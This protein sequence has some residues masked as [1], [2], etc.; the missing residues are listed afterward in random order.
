MEHKH[1]DILVI[2]FGK[3]G[4]TLAGTMG[5]L[6]KNVAMIEQSDTMYGG[7]CINIGCVPTKSLVHQAEN[8]KLAAA[9]D[10]EWHH[11]AVD[12]TRRLTTAM[13]G[14]NFETLDT[15]DT[16]TVITGRATFV[17]PKTVRVTAGDDV[18]I[19]SA[20][21][22]VINT[23]ATPALP[24]IPGLR[25]SSHILTSTELI[26]ID[27]LP[28]RL[29]IV[30]GGYVGVEFASM[31]AQFGSAITVLDAGSRIM[32]REDDDVAEAAIDIL[33]GADVTLVQDVQVT[34]IRDTVDGV[35]I[36]YERA[37][38]SHTLAADKVLAAVGRVPATE[39]LGL[40][41]AGVRTTATGAIEVD[42][43]LRTSQPHIFALG[44]VNG[45][46]QFTYISLDDS[47]IVTDQLT[48]DGDRSTDDRKHVP[49][50]V[51]MTP[52]L[53]RVGLTERAAIAQGYAIKVV[54][55]AVADLGA[56]PR[57]KIVGETR[58]LMKFVIDRRTDRILGAALLSVDSQE[59]INLVTL[60][61]R[62]DV[63]ASE[64]RDTIYIHPSSTEAFNEVL[65]QSPLRVTDGD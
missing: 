48:G 55:K 34:G 25:E 3:G 30:G 18:L 60:A 63:T 50:T 36:S 65:A 46:P 1:F 20:D 13:R 39:G 40:D 38:E 32:P 53:S 7:T 33:R 19:L 29:A 16:V 2:G 59:L 57:A 23:G 12:T 15:I 6:G 22:I 28:K 54:S 9:S 52:A 61:M 4:K 49:Y 26:D 58:G 5:R 44:D 27:H 37:G 11:Q 45:G 17:D 21:T 43:F 56:M 24:D 41:L 8:R 64:L 35:E 14:K 62:H 10:D 47:R 31:Y 42:R 51:F